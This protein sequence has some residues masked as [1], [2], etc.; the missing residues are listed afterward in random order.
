[1]VVKTSVQKKGMWLQMGKRRNL[2]D[3]MSLSLY[4][5]KVP[6]DKE[7]MWPIT[8]IISRGKE[9]RPTHLNGCRK[10]R[11]GMREGISC[12]NKWGFSRTLSSSGKNGGGEGRV[13]VQLAA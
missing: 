13:M 8:A 5:T 12:I 3:G 6:R 4:P 7:R 2:K 11:G 10:V 1:V 9:K